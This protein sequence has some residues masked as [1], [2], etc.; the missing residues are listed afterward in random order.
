MIAGTFI[1]KEELCRMILLIAATEFEIPSFINQEEKKTDILITGVGVPATLYHL[2]KRL[3]Q[4][5]YDWV[6]QAGI[7]GAFNEKDTLGEVVVV[8]QDVFGDLGMEEKS[9]FTPIFKSGFI[10][11]N[12]FP[13]TNGWLNNNNEIIKQLPLKTVKGVTVNKVSDSLLQKDQLLN[14]FNAAIESMEGAAL[15]YVCLQEK[16]SFI[17]LRSFSNYVGERDKSKWKIKDAINN[18]NK[19]LHTIIE[20]IKPLSFENH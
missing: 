20:L 4:I 3:Q 15:H 18:L 16:I 11:E 12:E 2:Q 13:F 8:G 19:E 5:D 9:R 7:G 1:K 17:Q 6:I 14:N 10:K